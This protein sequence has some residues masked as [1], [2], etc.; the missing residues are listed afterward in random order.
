M[1]DNR[2]KAGVTLSTC[3]SL[4]NDLRDS[5][6]KNIV[7]VRKNAGS[8]DRSVSGRI[9]EKVR[10]GD[11]TSTD[12]RAAQ[13]FLFRS[14]QRAM[15]EVCA[16][17]SATRKR[18]WAFANISPSQMVMKFLGPSKLFDIDIIIVVASKPFPRF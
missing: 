1:A 5:M 10:H 8:V 16:C 9:S 14:C 13:K 18:S 4:R 7:V 11:T 6:N 15:R 12:Q 3:V 17:R 2:G